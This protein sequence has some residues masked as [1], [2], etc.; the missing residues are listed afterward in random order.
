MCVT[1]PLVEINYCIHSPSFIPQHTN[2]TIPHA[3]TC[4]R[5]PIMA[6]VAHTAIVAKSDSDNGIDNQGARVR[7]R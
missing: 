6:T 4:T 5:A 1:T 2:T 7:Q 3:N